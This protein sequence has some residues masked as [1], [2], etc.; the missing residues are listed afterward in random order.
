MIGKIAKYVAYTAGVLGLFLYVLFLVDM[1]NADQLFDWSM[2]LF[3]V[4]FIA[5][6]ALMLIFMAKELFSARA[7]R[8]TI[9]GILG[10]ALIIFIAYLISDSNVVGTRY[11]AETAKWVGTGLWTLYL[12]FIAS[13]CV[14]LYTEVGK[15]LR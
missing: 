15:L 14:I 2:E 13:L 1:V 4:L 9:G 11:T 5:A 6:A 12:L 7:I 10:L 8:G 3:W